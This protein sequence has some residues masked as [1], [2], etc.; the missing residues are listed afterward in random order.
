MIHVGIDVRSLDYEQMTSRG[1]GR[2]TLDHLD[3][4]LK[5]LPAWNFTFF[6][7][8][9]EVPEPLAQFLQVYSNSQLSS[10]NS[11]HTS[12]LSL[13]HIPD[14][15]SIIPGYDSGLR[16]A[17]PYVP[18]TATF[19]DLIPL[20]LREDFIDLWTENPRTTYLTRLSQLKDSTAHLLPISD[21]TATDLNR[22]L[23]I[24]TDR[25]T[26]IYAG[27]ASSLGP[28]SAEEV[29]KVKEK[30]AINKPYL[31]SVGALDRHK[32]FNTLLTSFMHV[33]QQIP[34]QLVVVGSFCDPY[35]TLYK[36]YVAENNV[37]GVIFTGFVD[38]ETLATLYTGALC[39]VF[40]SR[41]EG[42]GLT[43]LEAM[44]CGCPV[45]TSNTSSLPEVVGDAGI[46]VDPLDAGTVAESILL[47]NSS[48]ETRQSLISAGL[49]RARK[50]TWQNVAQKT[51]TAWEGLL[52]NSQVTINTS[53]TDIAR[54]PEKDRLKNTLKDTKKDNRRAPSPPAGYR[55]SGYSFCIITNGAKPEKLRQT[56]ASILA[57]NI[58]SFEILIAGILPAEID[59]NNLTYLPMKDAA[60]NG[61]LGDMRNAMCRKARF[62][63]LV[64]A[65]DDMIFHQDFYPGLLKF[66]EDYDLLSPRLLNCDGSRYWDWAIQSEHEQKLISY[67][68]TSHQQYI[69]GGFCIMKASVFEQV[70][71]CEKRG[72]YQQEDIDFS[73]RLKAAGYTFKFNPHSSV[74]HNDEK[75]FQC[76]NKVYRHCT[77]LD[78][79][80]EIAPG[81]KG[82]DIS[83]IVDELGR[84]MGSDFYLSVSSKLLYLPQQITLVIALDPDSQ[85]SNDPLIEIY[86]AGHF[87]QKV[88]L[89][90]SNPKI[91][92]SFAI[93]KS[94]YDQE[95]LLKTI[96]DCTP[97][98]LPDKWKPSRFT[99][100]LVSF[101]ISPIDEGGQLSRFSQPSF[102]QPPRGNHLSGPIL[103]SGELGVISRMLL[104]KLG[105]KHS[106]LDFEVLDTDENFLSIMEED[107]DLKTLLAQHSARQD[108]NDKLIIVS[109]PLKPGGAEII[110]AQ[111]KNRQQF[112]KVIA[113]AAT[114]SDQLPD[115]WLD[116]YQ[117][118]DQLIVPGNFSK[119]VFARRF[120]E[121]E[122][123]ISHPGIEPIYFA[124]SLA[125]RGAATSSQPTTFL[126]IMPWDDQKGWDILIEGW[127]KAF[128]VNDDVRLIIKTSHTNS[129]ELE[130]QITSFFQ[131]KNLQGDQLANI[132]IIN[133]YVSQ[134]EMVELYRMADAFVLP[135]R[136]ESW[137]LTTWQAM[138]MGIPVITTAWGDLLDHLNSTNSLLLPVQKITNMPLSYVENHPPLTCFMRWAVP[139]IKVLVKYLRKVA[140][141]PQLRQKIGENARITAS[142]L[143]LRSTIDKTDG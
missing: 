7:E 129:A 104:T 60:D 73:R 14:L 2:Y 108:V 121:K 50:F 33:S 4:L 52:A 141:E 26:T 103:S 22:H 75:Y 138:A 85:Y 21:Y 9:G 38:N 18:T 111:I 119:N 55:L 124:D 57:Q 105:Q 93:N 34:L 42:F 58:P 71:W 15:M 59:A 92:L 39:H 123:T 40:L 128:T 44:A 8:S 65:D 16:I 29:G 78:E 137:A 91:Q 126:S 32:N 13:Y 136:G 37:Q 67:Q 120:P 89:S 43:P 46:L 113:Y 82:S 53:Y 10:L 133:R 86:S 90:K 125:N 74:T 1:I 72:F 106:E 115:H 100:R 139:D 107:S 96:T 142:T 64:V 61:R 54:L 24:S 35:F 81:V 110:G 11:L 143:M 135:S 88:T 83:P 27:L 116:Q 114:A 87:Q 117:K 79:V 5:L 130:E 99:I 51:A 30:F 132:E 98:K 140:A 127:S 20:V 118:V 122:I 101:N 63:H 134:T 112:N 94:Y 28:R 76:D 31:L 84:W 109:A 62:D 69:T 47:F 45:I 131:K 49:K 48:P 6:N 36:K 19:Y 97:G 102:S 68:E 66:G 41:Y 25:M 80:Y 12:N 95:I 3:A 17:P 23:N 77:V 70:Q 56:I